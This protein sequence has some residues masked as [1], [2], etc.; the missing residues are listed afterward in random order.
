M[1]QAEQRRNLMLGAM[2]KH[3]PSICPSDAQKCH[4]RT[5]ATDATNARCTHLLD[6]P[7]VPNRAGGSEEVFHRSDLDFTEFVNTRQKQRVLRDAW[8]DPIRRT[9]H[10]RY[11]QETERLRLI[12]KQTRRAA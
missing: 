4:V 1:E 10:N 3:P 8:V 9:L 7:H 11:D 12:L 6:I 2:L 5:N